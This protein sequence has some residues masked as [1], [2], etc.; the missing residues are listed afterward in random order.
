[1][2]I[3]VTTLTIRKAHQ[4]LLKKEFSVKDL[5]D[6][7]LANINAHDKEIHAFLEVF[8]DIEAQA[9]AAQKK[10][11]DGTATL[12]TGIPF[13]MKDNMLIKGRRVGSA[14]K[15]LEGYVAP[16][17]ATVTNKLMDEGAVFIGRTNMDE[18]AM[19]S[20]TE[21]SAYGPTKNPLD[22]TRVP[23][24]SSG[25]SAAAVAANFVLAAIGSD[26]GGSIRQPASFCGI[27]GFKPTYG[28]VSRYGLMAMGSSLDQIGPLTK[29][30]DDAE[31]IFNAIK[32]ND[33]F[34]STTIMDATYERKPLPKK[35]VIGV[36]RKFTEM[37]GVDPAVLKN[38]N[39]SLKKLQESGCEIRDIEMPNIPYSLAVYYVVMPAEVSSNLARFD[40]VKYGL[41]ESGE[42]LIDDYRLTRG[43]G[44]GREVRRRIILGTYV[45]SAGYHDAYYNKAIKVRGLVG[46]DF[47]KAFDSGIH[48]IATPTSPGPAFKIGEKTNDPLQ[49]YLA[50]VFTVT[51][52]IADI[53]AISI[54][55]GF[56]TVG[57]KALPLGLQL[58]G[59]LGEEDILFEIGRKFE[60][61]V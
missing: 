4:A 60:K 43:K 15:I 36:P 23:G 19:G 25:G 8:D 48:V 39:E 3:D 42:K 28:A 30:V 14:S 61:M 53:P 11:D 45:L 57:G 38:F 29:T 13:A 50:D 49:M 5:T 24:G 59:P 10:F 52:N 58:Q 47:K 33:P 16:Y 9:H 41:R 21:N 34:D 7:Y 22:I 46:N 18:F 2:K 12:L 20:S 37:E 26:T 6:V 27:V 51:A 55:S 56:V 1:M 40:G 32:G 31:I 44:F 17:N 35:V 54:P